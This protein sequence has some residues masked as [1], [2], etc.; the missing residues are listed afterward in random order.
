[1]GDVSLFIRDMPEAANAFALNFTTGVHGS[2][3][4]TAKMR[5][6]AGRAYELYRNIKNRVVNVFA[7]NRFLWRGRL[8]D[9]SII[10]EGI[11]ITAFGLWRALSDTP[12]TAL[13]SITETRG[14][15]PSPNSLIAV[16]DPERY[17]FAND[18]RVRINIK[19]NASYGSGDSYGGMYYRSPYHGMRGIVRLRFSY[20]VFLPTGWVFDV[21]S[22]GEGFNWFDIVWTPVT[23]TGT[24][25]TGS[26]DVA[27]SSASIIEFVIGNSSGSTYTNT[28]EDNVYHAE[29]TNIRITTTSASTVTPGPIIQDLLAKTNAE[30]SELPLNP[31]TALIADSLI[32]LP[33]EIYED[34]YPSEIIERFCALGDTAGNPQEAGVEPT[35]LLYFR[36][37][38]SAARTW[39][40]DTA[41]LPLTRSL[42]GLRNSAYGVYRDQSGFTLR[43]ARATNL[44]SQYTYGITRTEPLAVDSTA[45]AVATQYRDVYIADNKAPTTR[46][47]LEISRVYTPA[48]VAVPLYCVAAGDNL[49]VRNVQASTDPGR[50]GIDAFHISRTEYDAV[51]DTLK[52]EPETPSPTL[53]ALIYRNAARI[54]QA[55]AMGRAPINYQFKP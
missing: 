31:S 38:Y 41:V 25:Q 28:A 17:I 21:T 20:S 18:N 4:L 33:D 6:S 54:G 12:Y 49:I 34:L 10:D 11:E 44:P 26:V 16:R 23:G 1:M 52:V 35:G 51:A 9:V 55:P 2:E 24:L 45:A 8:E 53:D 13:W 27:V 7:D 15:V 32:D 47:S 48:G 40:A 46:A 14:F 30:Y 22:Y 36:D 43:T 29:V 3:T 50:N 42:E 37:K 39:Y 19:K 5:V